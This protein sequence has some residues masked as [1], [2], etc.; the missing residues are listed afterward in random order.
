MAAPTP[1][2]SRRLEAG[3]FLAD[4][5]PDDLVY[6]LVN[7]GDGDSQLVLL[8][9]TSAGQRQAMVVDTA[10]AAKLPALVESLAEVGLLREQEKPFAVVVA[11]HPHEDHIGGMESFLDRF[12]AL[13]D[14]FW[15]PGYYHPGPSYL[16]MMRSLEDHDIRHTQ[17]T[18]G[19]TRFIGQVKVTV[20]SPSMALRNRF[21][22]YGVDINDASLGLKL[23]FPASRVEQRGSDRRFLRR[24][25]RQSLILGADAQTQSWAQ[26]MG[27]FP[28]LRPDNSPAAEAIGKARGYEPLS[29]DVFKVP[30]HGSKH[31]LNLELVE[32]I[33][34]RL[35][36][37]SSVAQRGK[38]N[39][40]HAVTQEAIR[41]AL[42]PT[43]SSARPHRP[44]HELG[45]FYTADTDDEGKPLGTA[46]LVMAPNGRKRRLWRF[47]DAPRQ[48]VQ[49]AAARL[50]SPLDRGSSTW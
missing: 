10:T 38:Y 14:E 13:V 44:D 8:P 4:I 17:P 22:S 28:N 6:F 26:V 3:D 47:G 37:V 19:M 9:A 18:S 1:V 11:T 31:G 5:E 16:A 23:E 35:T 36:F 2:P 42:E 34:P 32:L 20:L 49:F 12:H 24:A 33:G 15:E 50:L 29:A 39:F 25:R 43:T 27:D 41:E 45:L 40:P 46:A 7:V 21:D 30:H 48:S